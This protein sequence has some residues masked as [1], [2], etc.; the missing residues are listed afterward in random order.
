MFD[1]C[2][3]AANIR[4]PTIELKTCPECGD[5][6]EMFSTDLQMD[7]PSCGRTVYRELES[8]IQWCEYARDC[9]GEETY[10]K[11]MNKVSGEEGHE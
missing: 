3:G 6:V 7:C 10:E 1:Q 4:T 9:V 11:L 2:P 5:E 8:C